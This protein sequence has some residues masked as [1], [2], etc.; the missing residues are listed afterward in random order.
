[1]TR[2]FDMTFEEDVIDRLGRIET[3]LEMVPDHETRLRSLETSHN[4]AAGRNGL[5]SVFGGGVAAFLLNHFRIGF[6]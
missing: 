2:R 6:G 1:M 5:L 3:N 4:R